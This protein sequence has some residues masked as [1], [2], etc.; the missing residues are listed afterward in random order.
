MSRLVTRAGWRLVVAEAV[1]RHQI[2]QGISL[3]HARMADLRGRA[4]GADLEALETELARVEAALVE[5]LAQAA[6]E[7]SALLADSA[8]QLGPL[9][10]PAPDEPA[11][12]AEGLTPPAPPTAQTPL[13]GA[14]GVEQADAAARSIAAGLRLPAVSSLRPGPPSW[15]YLARSDSTAVAIR[16]TAKHDGAALLA[17]TQADIE[18]I[19]ALASRG[20]PLL[21]FVEDARRFGVGVSTVTRYLPGA[22]VASTDIGAALAALHNAGTTEAILATLPPFDPLR[23]AHW[24]ADYL[25]RLQDAGTPLRVGETTFPAELLDA[26]RTHLERADDAVKEV[27]AICAERGYGFTALHNDVH[28]GNVRGDESGRATL[29]DLD[30]M[31]AGPAEYDLCRPVGQWVQRFGRAPEGT[32]GLLSGYRQTLDRPVDDDLLRLCVR[33][34]DVRFGTSL[35]T[36]A[37]EAVDNGHTAD[38]WPLTE[39]MHRLANLDDPRV[40]W[41]SRETQF[42]QA[43]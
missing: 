21:E 13:S 37:A 33:I 19:N 27:T 26:F 34:G 12:R 36:L 15:V 24:T 43:P 40:Q 20:A 22:Q 42:N 3:V 28:P 41:R 10:R 14:W 6:D 7:I 18:R 39:G 30:G 11:S 31:S 9:L 29:I 16:L 2:E 1:A 17:E 8:R 35:I 38:E 23:R 5:K 32:A 4:A 25:G